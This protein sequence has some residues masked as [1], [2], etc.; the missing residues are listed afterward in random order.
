[1]A[2]VIP[3]QSELYGFEQ[4]PD[5]SAQSPGCF[6]RLV[7]RTK[8]GSNKVRNLVR[9]LRGKEGLPI[10]SSSVIVELAEGPKPEGAAPASEANYPATAEAPT[11]SG[12]GPVVAPSHEHEATSTVA[13]V[14]PTG[15][16]TSSNTV[17]YRDRNNPQDVICQIGR[18][19]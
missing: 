13:R 5:S 14:A 8:S 2:E 15:K 11:M 12:Q 16:P 9:K 10:R 18:N 17:V 19:E 1:M 7:N 4:P 6:S 3:H